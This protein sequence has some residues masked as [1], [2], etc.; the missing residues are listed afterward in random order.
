MG[1]IREKLFEVGIPKRDQEANLHL[2]QCLTSEYEVDI[3]ILQYAPNLTLHMIEDRVRITYRE[4]EASKRQVIDGAA[5][6]LVATG[7]GE[8]GGQGSFPGPSPGHYTGSRGGTASGGATGLWGQQQQQQ[9]QHQHDQGWAGQ[10]WGGAP[11]EK[12]HGKAKK[13]R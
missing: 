9:Q 6:V 8:P 10:N 11:S 7:V 13:I 5:Q 1:I 4:L 12:K 2:L 3:K